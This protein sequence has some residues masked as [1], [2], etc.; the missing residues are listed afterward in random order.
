MEGLIER[1][2][3]RL[4]KEATQSEVNTGRRKNVQ[5][6]EQYNEKVGY[7]KGIRAALEWILDEARKVNQS[8]DA[9]G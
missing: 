3:Q 7:S 6:W 5:S 2:K 8:E 4:E 1:V 9:G